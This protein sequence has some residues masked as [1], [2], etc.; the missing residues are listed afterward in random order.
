MPP[1]LQVHSPFGGG[2]IP[3]G[4]TW[5]ALEGLVTDGLVRHIGVSNFRVADLE[6]LLAG[7]NTE[8]V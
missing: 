4:E 2:D 1:H 5:A 7:W 8:D 3:I 6:E